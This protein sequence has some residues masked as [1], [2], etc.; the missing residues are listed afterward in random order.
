M[1]VP[2]VQQKAYGGEPGGWQDLDPY[3]E[4]Q[5]LYVPDLR[6]GEQYLGVY[7]Q[8]DSMAPTIQEGDLVLARLLQRPQELKDGRV[9]IICER[10]EGASIKRVWPNVGA[11]HLVLQPDNLEQARTL[12]NRTI[13][14]DVVEQLWE[15]QL[16][17]TSD[18]RGPSVFDRRLAEMELRYQQMHEELQQIRQQFK[19][20]SN[21]S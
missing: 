11:G 6:P 14:M 17:I 4:R 15:V 10:H 16:R 20:S 7:V 2:I 9:Y 19:G 5:H 21:D 1:Q 18:L 13:Y 3:A 12:G 8:G